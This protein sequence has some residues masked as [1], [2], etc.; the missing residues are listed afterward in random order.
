MFFWPLSQRPTGGDSQV[1]RVF[2]I[3]ESIHSFLS[4][5]FLFSPKDRSLSW[6][7]REPMSNKGPA[8]QPK[9]PTPGIG[10]F[11]LMWV[12]LVPPLSLTLLAPRCGWDCRHNVS[13]LQTTMHRLARRPVCTLV[14]RSSENPCVIMTR[15]F[16]DFYTLDFLLLKK[17]ISEQLLDPSL[18][19]LLTATF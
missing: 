1:L 17:I 14:I 16:S 11:M 19:R 3:T 7:T 15:N 12:R 6:P 10:R 5:L 13:L 8:A 4:L 18:N 9:L 2:V